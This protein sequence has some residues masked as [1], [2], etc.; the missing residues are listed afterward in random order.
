MTS[1]RCF[2]MIHCELHSRCYNA[3][4]PHTNG[5]FSPT[6]VGEYCHQFMPLEFSEVERD[7]LINERLQRLAGSME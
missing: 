3:Q 5:Y 6:N 2:T 7:E 4:Q 1:R